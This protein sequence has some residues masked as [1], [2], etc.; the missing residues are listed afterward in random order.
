VSVDQTL[1]LFANESLDISTVANALFISQNGTL[2]SGTTSVT[3]D[4][5][6]IEFAPDVAWQNN[7]L[8]QIFLTD[9]AFDTA[10]N[11]MR[12]YQGQFRTVVDSSTT[13]RPSVTGR[14]IDV[15]SDPVPL[16]TI[17]DIEFSEPLNPTTVNDTTVIL[18]EDFRRG[19]VVESS[20][21]LIGDRIIRIV[22]N[23]ALMAITS[24]T[25]NLFNGIEDLDG[26]TVSSSTDLAL[27]IFSGSFTTGTSEDNTAPVIEVFSPSSGASDVPLNSNFRIHFDEE[28]N[29]LTVN[30]D[31]ILITDGTNAVVPCTISISNGNREVL[32]IPHAP[33]SGS[34]AY[35]MTIQGVE[36]D[37]GNAVTP[38]STAFTTSSVID[39]MRP[40]VVAGTPFSEA[41][42][43]PVN[44]PVVIEIN[45][46]MDSVSVKYLTVQ[47]STFEQVTGTVSLSSNGRI[48][49][50]VPDAPFAVGLRHSVFPSRFNPLTD[51]AGNALNFS[52]SFTT[53]FD[54]DIIAPTLL[55]VIPADGLSDMPTNIRMMVR[56]DEPVQSVTVNQVALSAGGSDIAVTRVL[57][58]GNRV[59]TLTPLL[60][61]KATTVH[62]INI[63]SGV[64]D[65]AGND[66]AAASM[67]F[68]TGLG[69]DLIEPS[70]TVEPLNGTTGVPTNMVA[71]IQ[72]SE[73]VNPLT[74]TDSNF[75]IERDTG[76]V[77]K[78]PGSI[79]VAPDNMSA[80][81]TPDAALAASIRYRIRVFGGV[82]D[83]A[84]N[85]YNSSSLLTN[86]TTGP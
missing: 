67:Q 46:Q 32:V 26:Q 55:D 24:Y 17:I 53:A 45:E 83:L 1:V 49:S 30:G 18:R 50:F 48:I 12:D 20:V 71:Q 3:P 44:S 59:L 16:N 33:L 81:Y 73:A 13:L 21:S 5:S 37:T 74:V 36:D 80:T 56:F 9:A 19:P 25:L 14:S 28:V 78:V 64:M 8:I 52:L 39:T 58:N 4:G 77:L 72:F 2:I 10:G 63:G 29:L 51:L 47:D 65:L 15:I 11:A 66:L 75:F 35:T 41:T 61:L 60:P 82:Q 79:T 84:G 86:F 68:T 43:V 62:T 7:A 76:G 42:D 40:M 57:S 69:V 70:F 22:P 34:T 27:E 38:Q 6:G 23:T 31:T 85:V 54:E